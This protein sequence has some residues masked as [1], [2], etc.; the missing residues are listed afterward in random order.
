MP[1][2][3]ER[4]AI[5]DDY[6]AFLR[7][8]WP[9][10][11]RR[12]V[13]STLCATP[14]LVLL[15]HVF[16]AQLGLDWT[17]A[18]HAALRVPWM[19]V[20]VTGFLLQHFFSGWRGLP[21]SIL[22]LSTLWVL[23]TDWGLYHL[24]LAGTAYQALVVLVC[25]LTAGVFLPL[26]RGGRNGLFALLALCHVGLDLGLTQARSLEDRLW[27]DAAVLG[28]LVTVSAIFES[29]ATSQRRN[30]ALRQELQRTVAAL[31]RSRERVSETA[32]VLSASVL[33]LEE[34]AATLL[35]RSELSG[36]ESQAMASAS[37]RVAQG[38]LALQQRSRH[39]SATAADAQE[40]AGAVGVL[41]GHIE[42]GVKD[43]DEAVSRSEA[44]FR[45]LQERADAIGTFVESAQEIA[46]QT[47]MLAV[48]AGIEAASAGEHGRGFAVIAQEVRKLAQDSGKGA[49]AI[50]AVVAELRRQMQQ[51]LG[52]IESVRARTGHFTAVFGQARSTLEAVHDI[53][54][55]LG[56][57][58]R[59]NAQDADSQ[60]E[61]SGKLSE[62]TTRL[63]E[64]LQ[65]QAEMSA[66]VASTSATLASH[67]DGLR[68]L[69]PAT[70]ETAPLEPA[71]VVED[72]F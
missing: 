56:E 17:L 3:S 57:A 42:T 27:L 33:G 11:T 51:L 1:V 5:S 9:A 13:T 52:A 54:H 39:S 10:R 71:P 59:E 70:L 60:A 68:S 14:V 49:L 24:G 62:S 37:A 46:A 45:Q 2:Q 66:D 4:A 61:A 31:E 30:I 58:M 63:R 40:H 19:L 35:S 67:A 36:A 72:R 21:A 18:Q 7:S 48:N 44:S 32:S 43:I 15:D 65:A 55:A 41:L 26:T 64:Q 53:V 29:F 34:S 38:A 25:F 50:N 22:G 47:H 6:R 8:R 12:L 28:M 69:L 20:P 16:C 23:G